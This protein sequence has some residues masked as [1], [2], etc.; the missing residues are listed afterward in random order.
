M[1]DDN[2]PAPENIPTLWDELP[3]AHDLYKGQSW[4]WDGIDWHVVVGGNYNEPSFPH[5][6]TPQ[7]KLFLDLFL[8]FFP[9]VWFTMVLVT[10][11]SEAVQQSG[12]D[13]STQ[14]VTFGEMIRFLGI[15]LLMSTHQGGWSINDY[16]SYT[17]KPPDQESCP[18]PANM[19]SFMTGRRFKSIQRFLIR[20][21]MYVDKFWE[22]RQ[23]IREWN[24]HMTNVFLARWVICLDESM[25]IW[26]QWWTCP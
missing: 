22:I 24:R 9:M 20:A 6:S 3:A 10:K 14:P 16:W 19:R 23:M 13:G 21:P 15:R 25:S 2:D 26:H 1:D 5:G 4:G 18:C 17:N 7:G 12:G 8:Y 11:T